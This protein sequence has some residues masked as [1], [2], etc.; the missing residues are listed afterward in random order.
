MK[1]ERVL[2]DRPLRTLRR[3]YRWY[4][5][6][7]A[8]NVTIWTDCGVIRIHV[9]AGFL[10]DGRSGG[11]LLDCVAPNLGTTAEVWAWAVH[12]LLGHGIYG[13]VQFANDSLHWVL[14]NEASYSKKRAALIVGT[15]SSYTGW[16]GVPE[17][18]DESYS[19]LQRITVRH[20]SK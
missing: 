5:I 12:D 14:R 9:A 17:L 4:C 19:N 10:F 16:W 20:D 8:W 3:R 15:V 11:P 2:I 1:V 18:G 7:H 6:P 13:D